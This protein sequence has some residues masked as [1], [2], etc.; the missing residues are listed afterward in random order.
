MTPVLEAFT[1]NVSSMK[2]K[3]ISIPRT[4]LQ[5][6]PT[7]KLNEKEENPLNKRNSSLNTF[8]VA[9]DS[10]TEEA[11]IPEYR[12][13]FRGVM[14][15]VTVTGQSASHIRIDQG[16]E[17]QQLS[18]SAN[19]AIDPDLK[20][21]QYI[22]EIDNRF[23][24]LVGST[25]TPFQFNFLDDDQIASYYFSTASELVTNLVASTTTDDLNLGHVILG[26]KGTTLKLYIKSSTDLR[27]ST[28]LFDTFGNDAS[29]IVTPSDGVNVTISYQFIDTIV[30]VTGATTGSSMDLPVR[31]IKQG[32][33]S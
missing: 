22:V 19:V 31:F 28:Y 13:T 12:N 5:Y 21:T 30:R 8:L 27:D 33:S 1:N 25:G 32:K 6:L 7:L 14:L 2:S 4:N 15:G 10:D 17:S 3:L 23:G 16:L 29:L 24:T 20:E 9:V 26:P 18:G 11:I